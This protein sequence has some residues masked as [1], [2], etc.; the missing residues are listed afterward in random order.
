MYIQSRKRRGE[1]KRETFEGTYLTVFLQRF[2]LSSQNPRHLRET[3]SSL[4]RRKNGANNV[5]F[6]LDSRYFYRE[7]ETPKTRRFFPRLK[8]NASKLIN[9]GGIKG[10]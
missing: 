4:T 10:S 5:Q 2:Y 8:R 6:T 1:K 3:K 9:P 7:F